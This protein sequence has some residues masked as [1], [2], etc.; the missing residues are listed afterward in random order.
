MHVRSVGQ[1]LGLPPKT[2]GF[3]LLL[4]LL[5]QDEPTQVGL[6]LGVNTVSRYTA[7]VGFGKAKGRF[8][9]FFSAPRTNLVQLLLL[10]RLGLV[11]QVFKLVFLLQPLL[12]P[13]Y[14]CKKSQSSP[15]RAD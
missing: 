11:R 2:D 14:L 9:F 12:L 8:L 10:Q 1:R 5:L 6:D 15:L 3:L 4:L 7:S 13:L